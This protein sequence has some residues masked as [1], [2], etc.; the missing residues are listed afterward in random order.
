MKH[1]NIY[2]MGIPAGEESKQGTENLFE[3]IVTENF[4]NLVKEKTHKSRKLRETQTSWNPKRPT[5]R[6]IIIKITRRE[7]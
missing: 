5:S 4:P 7:S 2:I 1:H 6:H 3:E